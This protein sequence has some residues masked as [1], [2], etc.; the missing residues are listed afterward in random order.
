MDN[1]LESAVTKER[2][3][4]SLLSAQLDRRSSHRRKVGELSCT[5]RVNGVG[6][7]LEIG[8]ISEHGLQ[9]ETNISVHAGQ[10]V[11]IIFPDGD[12]VQG[13][14]RWGV[15]PYVGIMFERAIVVPPS[16]V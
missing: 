11:E 10:L 9:G 3:D 1:P 2:G 6:H 5:L 16:I 12:M 7:A 14:V 13:T 8:D 4:M 15:G